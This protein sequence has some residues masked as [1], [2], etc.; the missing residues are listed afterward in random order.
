MKTITKYKAVDGKE[1][2]D[3]KSCLDYESLISKVDLIMSSL[4]PTI[5]S[6]DFSN[7]CGFIQ[8]DKSTVKNTRLELLLEIKKHV[9]H[10]WIQQTIEDD[11]IHGSWVA[12]ILGDYNINPLSKA[13]Y[14]FSC[15]DKSFREWGQPYYALNPDK[16]QLIKLL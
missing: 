3:E 10:N 14:R 2:N 5:D 4:I 11:N 15:I 8:Q 16:G 7:G 13:W 12:R 1:F 9:D 6:T